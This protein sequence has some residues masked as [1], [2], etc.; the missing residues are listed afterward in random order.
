MVH[1][2]DDLGIKGSEA[3][4]IYRL[5]ELWLLYL[6][7]YMNFCVKLT[8]ETRSNVEAPEETVQ[9]YKTNLTSGIMVRTRLL[10]IVH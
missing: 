5:Y 10:M 3:F 6:S 7:M 4:D 9:I 2:N 1:I 8:Q